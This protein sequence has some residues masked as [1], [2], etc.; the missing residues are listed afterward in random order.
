MRKKVEDLEKVI[1]EMAEKIDNLEIKVKEMEYKETKSIRINESANKVVYAKTASKGLKEKRIKPKGSVFKF[2]AKARNTVYDEDKSKEEEKS[3]KYFKCDHCDHKSE[4]LATLKK[5]KNTK[6]TEQKCKVCNQEFKTSIELET[7]VA[8]GHDDQEEVW[9]AKFQSTPKS[10]K[11]GNES[12]FVFCE[13][14]L[15]EFLVNWDNS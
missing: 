12:S 6:H 15:D 11:E 8:K 3:T 13:S 9:S 14:M 10:D 7:H 1:N 2:G 4:K 5:H